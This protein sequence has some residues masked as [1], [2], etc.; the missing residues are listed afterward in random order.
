MLKA[1]E[2]PGPNDMIGYKP[3]VLYQVVLKMLYKL[4]CF[5]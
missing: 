1:V 3:L 5:L 4:P 2:S